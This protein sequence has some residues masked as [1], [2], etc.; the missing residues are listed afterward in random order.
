MGFLASL[1]APWLSRLSGIVEC[2]GRAPKTVESSQW[3]DSVSVDRKP[4][5]RN[6]RRNQ[7]PFWMASK[8]A[9]YSLSINEQLTIGCLLLD[10]NRGPFAILKKYPLELLRISSQ[11][12]KSTSV[13]L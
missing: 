10:F 5:S 6:M 9:R 2:C 13:Y 1:I 7:T 8:N 3:S 12:P 11:A 4:S